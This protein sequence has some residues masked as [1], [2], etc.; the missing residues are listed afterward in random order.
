MRGKRSTP[1]N[2][3]SKFLGPAAPGLK[4]AGPPRGEYDEADTGV[5]PD[6][7]LRLTI[8]HEIGHATLWSFKRDRFGNAPA[9]D[10]DADHSPPIIPGIMNGGSGAPTEPQFSP[11]EEKLL[12]GWNRSNVQ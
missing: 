2:I 11:Y 9:G 10:P 3:N 6:E 5:P 7:Y 12:I 4:Q 8:V 1:Q